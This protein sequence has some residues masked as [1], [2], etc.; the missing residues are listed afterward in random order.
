[1]PFGAGDQFHTA[2]MLHNIQKVLPGAEIVFS[3]WEGA[4]LSGISADHII[5]SAD[6]GAVPFEIGSAKPN[7]INRMLISTQKGLQAATRPYVLKLRSDMMPTSDRFIGLWQ[8]LAKRPKHW[9][10]FNRAV[11]AYPVYSLMFEDN[12]RRMPKPFHISDWAFFGQASDVKALFAVPLVSEP[13]YSRYFDTHS[14]PAFDTAPLVRWQYSPEQY[15]FYSALKIKFPDMPPLDHK[16]DYNQANIDASMSALFSNFVFLDP[17][18][19]GLLHDKAEYRR[20]IHEYDLKCYYG[21][22]QF[23]AFVREHRKYV[24][25]LPLRLTLEGARR[26]IFSRAKYLHRRLV[27]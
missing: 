21:L 11:L 18:Q 1:M 10:L 24:G 14:H 20:E 9:P 27:D 5:Q 26:L 15:L 3:T 7:N 2:R 16:R 17:D 6:P 19:W 4:D 25:P 13:G 22:I 8:K 12:E 23:G